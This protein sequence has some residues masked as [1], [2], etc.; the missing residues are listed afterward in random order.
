MVGLAAVSSAA[1]AGTVQVVT[2]YEQA[3]SLFGDGGEEGMAELI[4]LALKNGACAV[5][6]VPVADAEGYE[7]AFALL[8]GTEDIALTVC[9][10]TDLEVQ[11]ALRD[12]VAEASQARRERLCVVAG[13][14]GED[15]DGLIARAKAL[16]HE[17]AILVAPG[18]VDRAGAGLSGLAL[19]AAV[20][21]AIAG[22]R[23][24]A[25]PLGGAE[26]LGLRGLDRWL[27]DRDIDRLI[28][29][30]SPRWRAWAGLSAW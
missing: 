19:A 5:A 27:E 18:A 25:L 4:R 14:R 17:R 8:A 9:G 22:E 7:A 28:L 10:S 15:V 30:A 1:P 12:S 6:A 24:P 16:D 29:G 3:V 13:D 20:A 26:L 21:G 23:D 11:K 2:G